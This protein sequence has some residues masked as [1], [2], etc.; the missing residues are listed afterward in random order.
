MVRGCLH[1]LTVPGSEDK[2]NAESSK[3]TRLEEVMDLPMTEDRE[4][5]RLKSGT[6]CFSSCWFDVFY[7][8]D[9]EAG[10]QKRTVEHNGRVPSVVLR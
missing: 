8:G 2:T 9:P 4:L 3:N 6:L 5:V 7:T 10:G 1:A